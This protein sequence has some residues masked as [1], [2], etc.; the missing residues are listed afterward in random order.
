MLEFVLVLAYGAALIGAAGYAFVNPAGVYGRSAAGVALI[1]VAA[2][3]LWW[4]A[5]PA[6]SNEAGFGAFAISAAIVA[7]ALLIAI[8][9]CLAATVRHA[10]NALGV[11][12][13]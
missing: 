7:L 10:L 1:I 6:I 12:L 11:H 3:L 9:A 2:T 4:S 8:T 5:S 13:L